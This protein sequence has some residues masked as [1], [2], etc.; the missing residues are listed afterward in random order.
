M[1]ALAEAFV[2][3]RPD[4]SG[5]RSEVEREIGRADFDGIGRRKGKEF[6]DGVE[7]NTRDFGDRGNRRGKDFGSGFNKGSESSLSSFAAAFSRPLGAVLSNLPAFALFTGAATAATASVVRLGAAIAPAVGV[8]AAV[9]AAG[10]AAAAGLGALR[11]A[12]AGVG[13]AIKAGLTENTKAF[14]KATH[15]MGAEALSAVNAV[16]ALRPQLVGLRS[17][18]SG[19]FFTGF[20]ADIQALATAELPTMR[21]GLSGIATELGAAGRRILEFA[22]QGQT[23]SVISDA[24]VQVRAT[25]I[26]IAPTV[27]N[28]LSIFRDLIAVGSIFLPGLTAGLDGASAA[29]AGFVTNARDTG[30]LQQFIQNGIDVLH[31]LGDV[32]GSVGGI[33][34]SIFNAMQQAGGNALG[35]LGGLLSVLNAVLN[36]K[37]AQDAMVVVFQS[38]ATIT[39]ALGPAFAQ[40]LIAVIPLVPPL[41]QLASTVGVALAQAILALLPLITTIVNKLAEWATSLANNKDLFNGLVDAVSGAG[42][43]LN[44]HIGIVGAAAAAYV[45]YRAAVVAYSV[46]Q[47]IGTAATNVATVAHNIHSASVALSTSTLGTW[48]GV[49]GIEIGEW[50]AS[51]AATIGST[52]ATGAN[53]VGRGLNT[54]ALFVATGGLQVFIITKGLELVAWIR[55]TASMVAATAATLAQNAAMIVV[56]G[57]TIAWTAVQWLLNAA[58]TANPIGIVIVV[59]GLLVAAIIL[60]YTHSKTFRD[61]VAAAWVVVRSAIESAW[62]GIKTVFDHIVSFVSVT[63][64]NAFNSFVGAARSAWNSVKAAVSDP[65]N[66][67][68]RFVINPLAAGFNKIAG[69]FGISARVQPI[70]GFRDGGLIRGPGSGTSDSIL[71]QESSTGTPLRVS[72]GEFVVPA[73]AVRRYGVDFFNA[74]S[75]RSPT[76]ARYPG[77]GRSGFAF[78]GGGLIDFASDVFSLFSDP[79]KLIRA[80]V[81]AAIKR[82]PGAGLARD[83]V[84]GM[85]HKLLDGLVNL[86]TGGGDSAGG[87]VGATQALIRAQSGKPYVWASAGP[88]GFDCSGL[89]SMAWNAMHGKPPFHHTFSTFDEGRYFPKPGPG[90]FT[91]GYTNPGEVGAG[92]GPNGVGHTRGRLGT[93]DFESRGGDGV[94]IGPRAT[95]LSRFAHIAHYRRGGLIAPARTSIADN[96]RLTLA[97]GPNLVMNGRGRDEHLREPDDRVADLLEQILDKLGE[98]G[99]DVGRE[100]TG[101]SRR[102][103]RTARAG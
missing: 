25:L 1:V 90:L 39:A 81:E 96:G 14:T 56:R 74:M 46:G 63:I 8:V 94:V 24:L 83:I 30:K 21:T 31:Q 68:V 17:E 37:A 4:V 26:P 80:P 93:L 27:G 3:V 73:H 70:A 47:S 11:I 28:I 99:P 77:D 84:I 2:R 10:F 55:S 87:P 33:A 50:A 103:V 86:V 69:A 13:D 45:T 61:I 64:P 71:A 53:T 9:P 67:A 5:F 79:T 38:L 51:T 20:R 32:F 52:I 29:A 22:T 41:S 40:L 101:A 6:G 76:D 48:L 15:D 12:T 100:I 72:N 92:G 91:V 44:T 65:I 82:I 66:A 35:A 102:A 58:L 18:V 85:G 75:G 59:I 62:S 89:V 16:V 19:A 60:A 88:G 42:G 49:K 78:A 95:S 97:P 34:T 7:K 43:F 36:T 23:V 54:A 98:V 57:A